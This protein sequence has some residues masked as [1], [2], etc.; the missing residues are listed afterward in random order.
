MTE[1]T[2]MD[3]E[4]VA[5]VIRSAIE[6]GELTPGE[7]LAKNDVLASHYGVNKNTISKAI[8]KL[9]MAGILS[10]ASGGA[11]RVRIQP[12]YSVRDNRDYLAEKARVLL[13]EEERGK[14]GSSE[15]TTGIPVK[16]L[17]KPTYH[18]EVISCPEEVAEILAI[19][20][21]EKVL[22]R[23]YVTQHVENAG[24]SKAE[25]FI[26]YDIVKNFPKLL[27]ASEEPWPGGTF[28][29]LYTAGHEPGRM[30]DRL[31]TVTA[32]PEQLVAFDIPPTVP[33]YNLTKITYDYNER[34]LEVA[35]IPIPA[36]RI[37]FVV[38]TPLPRWK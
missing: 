37:E 19:P 22:K 36:D 31:K 29:Q 20:A 18:Y 1:E 14:F 24:I 7:K 35:F 9:K 10:G 2:H 5:A 30:E 33:M 21:G 28:H 11:T 12:P 16:D 32:T 26:P 4:Q 23:T 38:S 3:A 15:K 34:P 17:Y 6:A 25:S 13:P 8:G 27:D